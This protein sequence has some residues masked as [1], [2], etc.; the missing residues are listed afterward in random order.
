MGPHYNLHTCERMLSDICRAREGYSSLTQEFIFCFLPGAAN[1][2][3]SLKGCD[4]CSVKKSTVI[5]IESVLVEV[6]ERNMVNKP[7]GNTIKLHLDFL[8]YAN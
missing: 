2:Q 8:Q 7:I 6:A 5:Y 3:M 4:Q 1:L